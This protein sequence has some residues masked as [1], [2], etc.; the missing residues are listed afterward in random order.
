YQ[1]RPNWC[2]PLNNGPITSDEQTRLRADFESICETLNTS[3]SGF[4]HVAHDR[5]TFDDSEEERRA[6]FEKVW[7]SPGFSK[8]TSNY[9]DVLFDETANA[10][11]QEVIAEKIRSNVTKPP[12]AEKLDPPGHP[13]AGDPPPLPT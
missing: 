7:S 8:L 2:T 10:E 3:P 6:F 13:H 1:R 12:T 5:A 9:T 4:L 11:W